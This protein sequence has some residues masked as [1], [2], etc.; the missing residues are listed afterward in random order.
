VSEPPRPRTPSTRAGAEIVES[1]LA[2]AEAVINEH[3]LA[4][5]T[6][7]RVVD[8]AGVSVG[9]LY[10]YF[11]SKEAILAELAR[12]LEQRTQQR[13]I[14]IFQQSAADSL[15][16]LAARVVDEL[17][18]GI[19]GITFRRAL[20]QEVPSGWTAD[21]SSEVDATVREHLRDVFASRDDVRQGPHELMTW[22]IGHAIEGAIEAAVMAD[23]TLLGSDAFRAELIELVTRYLRY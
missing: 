7:Q 13:L 15:D 20:R 11:K 8:R 12:R 16:V 21:T 3:G 5:F 6:T 1:I 4:S 9:S 2:A 19:G 17:L 18:T 14:E 22:V 10:Q 23:A